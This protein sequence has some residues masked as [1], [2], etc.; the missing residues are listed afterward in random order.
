MRTAGK[1]IP[2]PS[3]AGGRENYLLGLEAEGDPHEQVVSID[4]RTQCGAPEDVVPERELRAKV[5]EPIF[6]ERGDVLGELPRCTHT[7]FHADRGIGVRLMGGLEVHAVVRMSAKDRRS[8]GDIRLKLT[9]RKLRTL[10]E[11]VPE[12]RVEPDHPDREIKVI[13]LTADA[14]A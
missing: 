11:R 14:E 5:G 8:K 6:A 3:R 13:E 10:H 2:G 7:H 9:V 12:H 4:I 1:N